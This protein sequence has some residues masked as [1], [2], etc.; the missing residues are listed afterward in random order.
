MKMNYLITMPGLSEWIVIIL[1]L[2]MFIL[3]PVLL[4]VFY[5]KNRQLNKQIQELT[6]EKNNLLSRLSNER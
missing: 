6:I 4:I 5:M 3:I 2:F 1:T